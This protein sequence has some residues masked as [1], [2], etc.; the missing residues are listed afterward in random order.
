MNICEREVAQA[1]K[2]GIIANP[3]SGPSSVAR[4]RYVLNKI[5]ESLGPGTIVAGL[6][7]ACREDFLR[8]AADLGQ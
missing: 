3:K 6:D 7:T 8:C 2:F 1:V 4:K 5:A